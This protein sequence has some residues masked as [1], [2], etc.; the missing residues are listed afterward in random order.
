MGYA[1]WYG[2]PNVIEILQP[3]SLNKNLPELVLLATG[4]VVGA[5]III[6]LSSSDENF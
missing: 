3:P 5:N 4:M 2:D 6:K 1:S